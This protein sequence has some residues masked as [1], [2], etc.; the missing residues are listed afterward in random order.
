MEKEKA[1]GRKKI[2]LSGKASALGSHS[3][4]YIIKGEILGS[5][6]AT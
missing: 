3:E 4:V 1:G 5:T 6:E 2:V